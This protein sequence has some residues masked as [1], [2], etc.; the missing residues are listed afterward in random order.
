MRKLIISLSV[1]AIIGVIA[2]LL[3]PVFIVEEGRQAV[4]IRFGQ[5]VN[6]VTRAGLYFKTPF[7]DTVE[8]YPA[9]ILSWDGDPRRVP[10][11]ENQFIWI[12]TAA[13]WKIVDPARFYSS[14][15]TLEAAFSR[16]D[17]VIESSVRTVVASNLL[18][19]AVRNSNIINEINEIERVSLQNEFNL[20]EATTDGGGLEFSRDSLEELATL[21]TS[22]EDQ[23]TVAKGRRT[24]SEEMFASA[25][26]V[27]P[28]FGIELIDIVIRQIRY[29][30]DLTESVYDRMVSERIRIAQAY[31]SYGEG[32]K[33]EI[34]GQIER[35][36]NS[37]LSEAYRQA[38]II[39]GE[40]DA[41]AAS[42][43]SSSY[44]QSP[45]FFRFWRAI[46]SYRETLPNFNSIITT[47]M[48]YFR[49]LHS[50]DG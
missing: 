45:T 4:I 19:E 29:S 22:G 8:Y 42:L 44:N 6:T 35:E 15:T 17:D 36:K 7:I 32:R 3:G 46:E 23:A 31:R 10:T 34:V 39:T 27:M 25:S 40:A 5:I 26:S 43:Y 49:Y 37:V 12:D 28:E 38:Q 1:L 9:K 41:E 30:D 16:L 13:R 11:Q 50:E 18:H 33:Q 48:D 21:I 20:E 2:F 24:L 14:V 47:D